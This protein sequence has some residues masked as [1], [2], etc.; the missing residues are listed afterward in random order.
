MADVEMTDAPT[1]P[2]KLRGATK[3][4]KSGAAEASS[5]GKKRFEV[6]K[7]NAVALWAWDIVV[8]NCAICRNHIMDLCIEC[9]ANQGSSTAEE[10]TVAWG[11][12]NHAFHFHCISRWLRTR[13]VCPLD[14]RDWEFQKYGR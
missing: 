7:W 6:K 3:S 2:A 13:Q 14:N 12:C 9:Q 10:C 5:E 1:A 11:I 8:D 4:S